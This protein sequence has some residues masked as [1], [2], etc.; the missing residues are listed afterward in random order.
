M[1]WLVRLLTIAVAVFLVAELLPGVQVRN[2]AVDYLVISVIFALVN[3]FVRPVVKLL[4]TP[5]ILL[6]L[7]LFLLV[8]N[9][10][11]FALTAALTTRLE[12]D[13]FV[14]A[15]LAGLLVAVVTWVGETA[16]GVRR[17]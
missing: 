16:L 12:V 8:V 7:G 6:T 14:T 17:S 3:M 5:F 1:R 15:V 13:G 9:A 2:E 4:A 11:M 10:A